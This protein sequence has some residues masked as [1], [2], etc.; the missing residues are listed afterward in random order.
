MARFEHFK[1]C[2]HVRSLG[3]QLKGKPFGISEQ[4]PHKI[5]ER[6]KTLLPVFYSNKPNG[7]VNLNRD[8]LNINGTLFKNPNITPWLF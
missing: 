2:E 5:V 6:R 1:Q 4:F 8:K 7:R 3:K